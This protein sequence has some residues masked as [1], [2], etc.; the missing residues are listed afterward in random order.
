MKIPQIGTQWKHK[1]GKLYE[2]VIVTNEQA[3]KVDYP[4]TVVY[5]D[6][7]GYI[8]SRTLDK[9]QEMEQV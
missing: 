9:W 1:S 6:S 4:I 2:V 7:E 5:K 3:T 8:W